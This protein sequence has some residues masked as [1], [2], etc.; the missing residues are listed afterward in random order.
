MTVDGFEFHEPTALAIVRGLVEL[1]VEDDP[2]LASFGFQM[3]ANDL[4]G[5]RRHLLESVLHCLASDAI[6]S[7]NEVGRATYGA[8][9]TDG[10]IRTVIDT[11]FSTQ[12]DLARQERGLSP[13]G[14]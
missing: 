2:A 13:V 4:C 11:Y 6:A 1:I 3:V 10:Q 8:D 5:T 9:L 14:D 12:I 7:L